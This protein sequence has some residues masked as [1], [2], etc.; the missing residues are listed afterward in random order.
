MITLRKACNDDHPAICAL[1]DEINRQH[2]THRPDVFVEPPGG[3]SNAAFWQQ[4]I[5]EPNG[6]LLVA[7][8]DAQ[9]CGFISARILPDPEVPFLR[10]RRVCRIGTVVVKQTLHGSGVGRQLMT[11]IEGWAK[12][13]A[14]VEIRLEVFEFNHQAK[15]FYDA[16][17]FR[18]QS[19]IMSKPLD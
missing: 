4:A 13:H 3:L 14:V 19:H 18:V 6:T 12:E 7:I 5:D 17:G 10:P 9:L 2:Y 11:A 15:R 1:A 16:A 8:R